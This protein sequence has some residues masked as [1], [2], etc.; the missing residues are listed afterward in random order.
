MVSSKGDD[1]NQDQN[2]NVNEVNS[3]KETEG[4]VREPPCQ[5]SN[6]PLFL[7][8]S[9]EGKKCDPQ[10]EKDRTEE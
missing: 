4:S 10:D 6:T 5:E 1:L 3:E 9:S 2:T 7:R 8:D